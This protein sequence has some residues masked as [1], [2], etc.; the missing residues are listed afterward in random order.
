MHEEGI[1][2]HKVAYKDIV[3]GNT[4]VD[5]YSKCHSLM[6]AHH[7]FVRLSHRTVVS[8][9]ALISGY[10]ENGHGEEAIDWYEQMQDDGIS[11]VTGTF[12]CILKACTSTIALEK[13]K[14]IHADIVKTQL[15]GDIVVGNSLIDMYAKCSLH[16]EAQCVFDKLVVQDE[17]SWNSLIAG[18]GEHGYWEEALDKFRQM[19]YKGISPD[20]VTFICTLKVCSCIGAIDKGQDIHGMIATRGFERNI[21]IGNALVDMYANSGLI[22]E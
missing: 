18:Y 2:P 6:E 16:G 20:D 5:M 17:V 3:I 8:W 1:C 21:V 9:T 7:V 11:A 10:V 4:M 15:E 13:A 14:A 19:Q 12:A 22:H